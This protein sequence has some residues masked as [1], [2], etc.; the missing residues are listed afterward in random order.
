[1]RRVVRTLPR[2]LARPACPV[3]VP[4]ARAFSPRA[5]LT[6]EVMEQQEAKA[7]AG[8]APQK[9]YFRMRAHCNPLSHNDSFAYPVC[10]EEMDWSGHYPAYF[11]SGDGSTDSG[12]GGGGRTPPA[13][14]AAR[15]G[16]AP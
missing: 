10:P 2:L 15:T 12:A 6:A 9:K 4:Y 1:M 13:R 3:H 8:I 7:R 16:L 5:T 14:K 11:P